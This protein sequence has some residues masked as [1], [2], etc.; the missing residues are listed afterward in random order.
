M[1]AEAKEKSK[2]EETPRISPAEQMFLTTTNSNSPSQRLKVTVS[3]EVWSAKALARGPPSAVSAES[4]PGA[5]G[6]REQGGVLSQ[7][8]VNAGSAAEGG[9][10]ASQWHG[11]DG[12][13]N[14]VPSA[15]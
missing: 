15:N 5:W 3:G 12:A 11:E 1:N 8:L 14:K 4:I 6:G 7:T 10:P 2:L 9:C 13:V